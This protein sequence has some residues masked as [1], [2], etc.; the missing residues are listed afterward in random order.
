MAYIGRS[1]DIG[2]FEKQVIT[3]DSSTTTFTLTFAVGSANSLLVVYGGVVQEPA[4]AYSVSGGGQQI[5]FSE[6]PVTGT[7][8]YIIYLGKQLTTPRAAGQETTKQTFAGDGST[9]TFTLTDPPV[10]PAG[11]MV[12]VDGILQREGSGNN[13]VSSGSTIS[14]T[15]AP[16][17]SAE[18]DVYTLVKEKVSIDTVADGSITRTKLAQSAPYWD[19]AGNVGINVAA[20]AGVL[21]MQKDQDAQTLVYLRNASTGTS[22]R[23]RMIFSG[24]ASAGNLSIGMHNSNNSSSPNQAWIWASGASSPLILGTVGTERIRITTSGN[25]G[26]GTSSPATKLDVTGTITANG[27]ISFAA[28]G[29][30]SSATGEI[31]QL[32]GTGL[33]IFSKT[34]SS[35]DFTL[36]NAGG[37]N[38][39]R[40]PTG[41]GTLEIPQANAWFTSTGLGIGTTLSANQ[42]GKNLQINQTILNDDNIDSNHLAKNAYYN[43]GWKYYSTGY[44]SKYTQ[45]LSIHSWHIAASGTVNNAISFTQAMTLDASGNLMVG[46]TSPAGKLNVAGQVTSTGGI[47]KANGAPSLVAAA[48]GEAILAPE[49][50]LGALLYGRGSTYDVT[51]GGRGTNVALAVLPGTVN[52]YIP[53]TLY[54]KCTA[55]PSASVFGSAFIDNGVGAAVLHQSTSITSANALQAFYNPNGNVGSLGTSGSNAYFATTSDYRLKNTIA[56]MTGALAKVAQLKPV[57]YKWNADGSDSQG[58]IAHELAE[59]CPQAVIGEKDDV[60][61]YTDESGDEQTRPKYQSVD[62]SFLVAT[63]AAAIQELKAIVDAQAV[64]IAALKAK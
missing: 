53:A 21:D 4:V 35:Y 45:S 19:G 48:A 8:T 13:Y 55:N 26:I 3:A 2:M 30:S 29:D 42:Y 41:T 58:F 57:T 31:K 39:L 12:F 9:V 5:V 34:G 10:V 51:I 63:L 49:S 60:E 11:I 38:L 1:V 54:L 28:N 47:F 25:V 36:L 50:T 24:D 7:T 37:S 44:A 56:P 15:S 43:S 14:F 61:T 22:A 23:T 62:T 6:A 16:D 64:E 40:N 17:S 32:T 18:I 20:P 27:A 59:V 33:T 46:T 52:I